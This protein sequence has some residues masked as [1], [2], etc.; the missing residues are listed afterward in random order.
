M[1]LAFSTEHRQQEI[2]QMMHA[3]SVVGS[4]V[5]VLQKNWMQVSTTALRS[6]SYR[7]SWS[8]LCRLAQR[9]SQPVSL[10]AYATVAWPF[11]MLVSISGQHRRLRALNAPGSMMAF[12]FEH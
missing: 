2:L 5:M 10:V 6:H 12:V 11:S 1:T 9:R 4:S 3:A 8:I 7:H